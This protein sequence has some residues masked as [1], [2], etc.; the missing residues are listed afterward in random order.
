[1]TTRLVALTEIAVTASTGSACERLVSIIRSVPAAFTSE[2]CPWANPVDQQADA[3]RQLLVV[4]DDFDTVWGA[5]NRLDAVLLL[6]RKASHD[7][8]TAVPPAQAA[9]IAL[10]DVHAFVTSCRRN[11]TTPMPISYSAKLR[12]LLLLFLAAVPMR[13]VSI[14]GPF[15]TIVL[16]VLISYSLLGLDAVTVALET[17][18]GQDAEDLPIERYMSAAASRI[19]AV[20][21]TAKAF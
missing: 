8:I 16:S 15:W 7:A 2:F 20:V 11:F 10:A 14:A 19:D 5:P 21:S 18:F 4:G 13:L 1:M 17:P 9:A 12:F 6:L 3:L